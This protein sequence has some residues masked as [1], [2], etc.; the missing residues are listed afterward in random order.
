MCELT[1][2]DTA[3]RVH[4]ALLDWTGKVDA[5]ASFALTI[6]SAVVG[7]IVALSASG[8]QLSSIHGFWHVLP[9]SL[10]VAALG[11]AILLAV[12]AVIPRIRPRPAAL[13]WRDNFIYVGHPRPWDPEQLAG[14]MR[15]VDPL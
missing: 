14:A 6:E 11:A 1:S 9:F 15:D 12:V 7:G 10:G 13:R 4:G 3:W 2:A 8:R 5:K